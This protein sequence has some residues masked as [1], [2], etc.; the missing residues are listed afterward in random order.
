[1][2]TASVPPYLLPPE[3]AISEQP[4]TTEDGRP[5]PE[6]LDHWDPFTDTEVFRTVEVDADAIRE[7]CQLPPDA[8]FALAPSWYSSR[9]RLGAEG[10]VV[11]LGT[12]GGL[13]RAPLSL[14]V[15]GAATGGRLDLHTRLVLRYAGADPGPISP[16]R[17][18]ATLWSEETRVALEGGSSRFPVTAVD[19]SAIQR[20][21]DDGSWAIEW[22]AE[23]LEAPVLGGLRLLVNSS[24]EA[25]LSALRSGSADSRANVIRRFITFDVARALVH[26]A[27]A[28]DRFVADPESFDEGSIG[29]MLFD[30][31]AMTWPGMPVKALLARHLEDPSRLDAE[32]QAHVGVL[33]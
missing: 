3:D 4:W 13:V 5:L 33:G 32:L 8:S 2:K 28:N 11:E 18:G 30:L 22:D 17:E 15:P 23:E 7:A 21:P 14:S 25:L 26:G 9:T 19:F 1:M 10:T 20:L 24:E 27:L 16:R 31:L 12:L 6:R 29:R